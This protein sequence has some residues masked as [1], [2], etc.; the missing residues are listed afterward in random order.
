MPPTPRMSYN[1][2]LGRARCHATM[3]DKYANS[4][5]I[6]PVTGCWLYQGSLNTDGYAQIYT[7]K[8]GDLNRTGRSAQTAFLLHVVAFVAANG[9]DPTGQVSHICDRRHCF[10]PD[11]CLDETPQVNNSRK[12]CPG[13]IYC[14][15]HGHLII[16]LCAHSPTCIRAPRDDVNCCLAIKESDPGWASQT[17]QQRY[18]QSS[19]RPSTSHS[20]ELVHHS[21]MEFEGAAFL[22]EA[23]RTGAI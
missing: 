12:G 20:R 22:E 5:T 13:P 6:D 14:S 4:C 15:V 16:D 3:H 21:S 11:H 9:R 18:Y 7:K 1:T 19:S 10:N 2:H 23:V 17:V 8:N